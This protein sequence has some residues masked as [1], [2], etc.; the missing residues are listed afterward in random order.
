[1]PIIKSAQKRMRQNAKRRAL[2]KP[3]R[4]QMKTVFTNALEAIKSGD[5]EKATKLVSFAYSVID[6]AAKKKI[7]EK[8][9]A[10]RRKSRLAKELNNMS[11]K[12]AAAEK[13]PAKKTATKKTAAKKPAAKKAEK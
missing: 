6:T 5:K 8:N 2:R 10:A 9:T 13:K 12:P 3:F 11:A 1:M 7:V 4:N